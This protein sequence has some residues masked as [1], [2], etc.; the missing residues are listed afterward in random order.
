MEREKNNDGGSK[1][2]ERQIRV[3][4]FM[5][6]KT[7]QSEDTAEIG[8]LLDDVTYSVVATEEELFQV[9]FSPIHYRGLTGGAL[10]WLR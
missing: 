9:P 10:P 6:Q 7:A 4:E 5:G 1:E 2:A 8:K 3:V